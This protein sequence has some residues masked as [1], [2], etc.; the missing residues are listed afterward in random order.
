M[1]VSEG[2]IDGTCDDCEQREAFAT[3]R[4]KVDWSER[5]GETPGLYCPMAAT[6]IMMGQTQHSERPCWQIAVCLEEFANSRF[7][8]FRGLWR[9]SPYGR[10]IWN[11]PHDTNE[12]VR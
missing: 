5:S 4:S 9:E 3:M 7:P 6:I 11:I 12:P 1:W 2:L 8:G 10:E